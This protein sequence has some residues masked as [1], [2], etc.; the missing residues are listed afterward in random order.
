[1]TERR[2]PSATLRTGNRVLAL[3]HRLGISPGPMYLLTVAGRETGQ[4]HTNPVAPVTIGGKLYL[5]QAFPGA[6]WV[7]NARQAG[8]GTLT[9]GRTKTPVL[10]TELPVDERA[11]VLREF[12]RQ[13]RPGVRVFVKN[14]VV[15][16]GDPDAFAAA[17]PNCPVFLAQP[18]PTQRQ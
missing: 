16:S 8:R 11:A 10:L 18:S 7:K 1:M 2:L 15:T 14:G 6:D 13:N 4:P 3:L 9:R 5:L 17:A 12:P